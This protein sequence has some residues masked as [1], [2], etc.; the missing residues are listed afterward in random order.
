MRKKVF[1]VGLSSLVL[2]GATKTMLANTAVNEVV[3]HQVVNLNKELIGR[4][5]ITMDV[6]G[7]PIPLQSDYSVPGLLEAII[8]KRI[9]MGGLNR[10]LDNKIILATLT[11][12]APKYFEP[13]LKSL[14]TSQ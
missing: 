13:K 3:R 6:N 12:F 4:W 5:D 10:I 9:Y 14:G 7:K 2:L 11:T 1:L 8:D